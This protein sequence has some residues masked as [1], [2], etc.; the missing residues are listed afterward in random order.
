M[1]GWSINKNMHFLHFGNVDVGDV[2]TIE[3][4]KENGKQ[5][6][7]QIAQKYDISKTYQEHTFRSLKDELKLLW[8]KFLFNFP[9]F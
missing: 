3:S 9:R 4:L 2:R 6:L 5:A 1:P 7:Q 8:I